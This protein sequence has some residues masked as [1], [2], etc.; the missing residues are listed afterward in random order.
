[1]FAKSSDQRITDQDLHAFVDGELDGRRYREVVHHLAADPV[2]AERVNGMLRQQGGFAF[3]RE[4]LADLEP[5]GDEH[6][7]DLARQLA[8]KVRRQRRVRL[9]SIVS[10]LALTS[11]VGSWTV[12]GPDTTSM[13]LLNHGPQVLFGPDPFGG[14]QLVSSDAH[15]MEE[16]L[17]AYSVRR[18]DLAS[19]GLTFL[20]GNALKTGPSPAFRLVYEDDAARRVYLFVGTVG[21]VGSDADAAL[22]LVP[23]GHVSLNWRRGSLVFVLIG[24]KE[25][26]QLLAVMQSISNFLVP[27]PTLRPEAPAAAEAVT[28]AATLPQD[29]SSLEASDPSDPTAPMGATEVAP[30]ALPDNRP[31]AL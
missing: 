7:L 25:S 19:H 29:A 23:E 27:V 5:T 4:H 24:P 22:T 17:A 3:L 8:G 18:P 21:T 10:A 2:D 30:S 20:G 1:M 31:K 12:W 16:Q 15:V 26:E 13:N 11:L 28:P 6:A 14:A 9:S